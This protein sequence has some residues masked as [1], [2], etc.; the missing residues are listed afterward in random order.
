MADSKKIAVIGFGNIGSGIVEA[1]YQKGFT[2]LELVKVVDIDLERPRPV[3][4]PPEYLSSD[5]EAVVSDPAIDIIVELIGGIEPAANI[6]LQ[7][8]RT[9]RT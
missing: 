1:L 4:L 7:A 2:G 8:L 5:W 6:Q 9:A 3:T